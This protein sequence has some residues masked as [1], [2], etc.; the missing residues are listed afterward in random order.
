MLVVDDEPEVC[1]L[2]RETL[3]GK[4]YRVTIATSG[5]QALHLFAREPFPVVVLDIVMA[6][7]D[8]LSV[9]QEVRAQ[10]PNTKVI[11]LTAHASMESV[12]EALR[13]G[14]FDYLRKG[15]QIW[16]EIALRVNK[17][18]ETLGLNRQNMQ[19][20]RELKR[21]QG[22]VDMVGTSPAMQELRQL[23][24]R[25]A[26]ADVN[27]LIQGET[28]TGKELVAKAIH[29]GSARQENPFVPVDC[30]I[31]ETLAEAM[32][33]G[34]TK[35]FPGFH[36]KEPLTGFFEL[37]DGGTLFLDEI[38]DLPLTVQ[39]KL[40]RVLQEGEIRP[41][42]ASRPLR[43]DVRVIAATNRNLA[44]AIQ[45]GDFRADLYYRLDGITLEAPPL[46]ERKSDIPALVDH[47]LAKA[48]EKMKRPLLHLADAALQTLLDY[49]YPGNVR[50]LEN[51]IDRAV[52]LTSG[53]TIL[54][55]MLP[56]TL[57]KSASQGL[58]ECL[59]QYTLTEAHRL[60]E[61]TYLELQLRHTQ[62]NIS[63]AAKRAGM[64][65]KNFRQKVKKHHISIEP[66]CADE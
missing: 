6:G 35:N 44:Q 66:L 63:Q 4:D 14:A 5:E 25:V 58:M 46:R 54:P 64:D 65:R 41:L 39:P 55:N 37:A 16:D 12:I 1:T 34:V 3:E 43:V 2:L 59:S 45:S 56:L 33:F 62:G 29:A 32:L 40:L 51:L 53:D 7:I 17:A 50:E 26:G 21:S 57:E 18:F 24:A 27:V 48:C 10:R 28:G 9:L 15:P 61:K 30:N 19:L 11:M 8:G 38:G 22:L 31:P 13:L 52:I 23:I 36:R 47:C 42:G 20:R 49:D 60:L